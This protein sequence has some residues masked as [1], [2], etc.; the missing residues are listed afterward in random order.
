MAQTFPNPR[1]DDL[2]LALRLTSLFLVWMTV[3]GAA[4]LAPGWA[5]RSL[6]LEGFGLD[7][8]LELASAAVL[9][10]RLRVETGGRA[11]AAQVEAVERHAA[12]LIGYTLYILAA[13]IALGVLSGLAHHETTDTRESAWAF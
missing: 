3:E 4:S 10:W 13:G 11:D 1:A 12:R 5:S 7:S 6:L 8:V 9:L 2:R